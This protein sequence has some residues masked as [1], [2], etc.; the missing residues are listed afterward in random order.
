MGHMMSAERILAGLIT[1]ICLVFLV[2]L[3]LN[4]VRQARFDARLRRIWQGLRRAFYQLR[5][6]RQNRRRQQLARDQAAKAALE[7]INRAR[8]GVE[9]DGN[10]IRPKAF[11]S[12][13]DE[14]G[15]R[16]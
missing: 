12:K 11:K 1:L 5:H 7:A 15:T 3:V 16:H 14:S 6:W 10:V 9:R 4:P 13:D 8:H 2:R